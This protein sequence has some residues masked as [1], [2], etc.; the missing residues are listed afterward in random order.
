MAWEKVRRLYKH[1]QEAT[2]GK[3]TSVTTKPTLFSS[4]GW[5]EN[6]KMCFSWQKVQ[7][8]GTS[9]PAVCLTADEVFPTL[10]KLTE[11]QRHKSWAV[12]VQ[13]SGGC[14]VHRLD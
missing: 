3:G 4:K 1:F 10:K 7:S 12:T 14:E 6:F 9:R 5:S 2:D 11:G 13:G 8:I